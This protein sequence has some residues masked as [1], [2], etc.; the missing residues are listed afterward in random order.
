MDDCFIHLIRSNAI[1]S[2]PV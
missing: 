2:T 1:A